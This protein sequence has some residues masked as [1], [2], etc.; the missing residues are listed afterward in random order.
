MGNRKKT[1][2]YKVLACLLPGVITALA[3]YVSMTKYYHG[4]LNRNFS[5]YLMPA[6]RFGIPEALVAKGFTPLYLEQKDSGWDGQF[7]YYI[8]NDLLGVT[9]VPSHIDADAYRYQRIGLPVIAKVVSVFIGAKWVSP[10]LY[11]AT[12]L[13]LVLIA[14]VLGAVF[15]LSEHVSAFWILPWSLGIGTQLTLLNGLP[16]AAA[17]SL[18]IISILCLYWASIF[19]QGRYNIVLSYIYSVTVLFAALSREIYVLIPAS[20]LLFLIV[21]FRPFK[22]NRDVFRRY[23]EMLPQLIPL[24]GFSM[25]HIYV[26]THFST[27]PSSQAHG[28]LGFPFL[29]LFY[30]MWQGLHGSYPNFPRGRESYLSGFNLVIFFVLLVFALWVFLVKFKSSEKVRLQKRAYN[31]LQLSLLL[32]IIMYFCFGETV[33]W[34]FSGFMKAATIFFFMVPLFY[35]LN[36]EKISKIIVL[37]SIGVTVYF[38]YKLWEF[39]LNHGPIIMGVDVSC[40]R[41]DLSNLHNTCKSHFVWQASRLPGIVGRNVDEHRVAKVDRDNAGYVTYGPYLDV[42]KG[43]YK[44]SIYY[45]NEI[46]SGRPVADGASYW[47]V[48]TFIDPKGSPICKNIL[49]RNN[50]SFECSF[51]V[52]NT[53]LPQLQIR[54]YF[55]GDGILTI[56]R[57]ELVQE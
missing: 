18:V 43:K 42:P 9:D 30:H 4:P 38:G 31:G 51:E 46:L 23:S 41:P 25:W 27:P 20:V 40:N 8:S 12:Q 3:A 36:G 11:Y 2:V 15:F 14:T 28:I 7:Y 34:H 33:I 1:F 52:M 10:E 37:L 49:I 55:D 13:A 44:V 54:S 39:R 53:K 19:K 29:N 32:T 35:V 45:T 21:D 47:E 57:V 5:H 24:V 48:G 22:V 50:D 56:K 17:D 26:R 6:K 16:D